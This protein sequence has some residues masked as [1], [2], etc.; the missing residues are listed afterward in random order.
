[1]L[2][3][4]SEFILKKIVKETYNKGYKIFYITEFCNLIPKKLKVSSINILDFI[5]NLE[6]KD[7]ISLKYVDEELFCV[8]ALLKAR[9]YLEDKVITI[10]K[11]K[12]FKKVATWLIL[13][14]F[15]FCFFACFLSIFI[16]LKV[17]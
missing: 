3:K 4:A 6:E 5:R 8:S 7:Y 9:I 13:F 14:N 1:M 15:I 10:K 16:V 17:M 2:D 12:Q 11:N